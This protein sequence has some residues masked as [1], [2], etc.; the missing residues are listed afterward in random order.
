MSF[1]V[2]IVGPHID[3]YTVND[4]EAKH[5]FRHD[6][7]FA[8]AEEQSDVTSYQWHPAVPQLITSASNTGSLQAWKYCL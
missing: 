4:N 1:A 6:G 7:H 2:F 3:I 8:T 5:M